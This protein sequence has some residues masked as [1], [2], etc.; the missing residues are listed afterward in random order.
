MLIR[1][2]RR[3]RPG[4]ARAARVRRARGVAAGSLAV[5]QAAGYA[6]E[7]D[8]EAEVEVLLRVE[9]AAFGDPPRPGR[10]AAG[11]DDPVEEALHRGAELLVRAEPDRLAHP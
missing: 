8:V 3:R 9:T 7:D 2:A 6:V 4:P 5:G 11:G 1:A 10:V